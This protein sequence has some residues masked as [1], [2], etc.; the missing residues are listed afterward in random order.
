MILMRFINTII[1]IMI[2]TVVIVVVVVVMLTMMTIVVQILMHI[3]QLCHGGRLSLGD[4]VDAYV[5][6]RHDH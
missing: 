5:E 3:G 4:Y 6:Q 2:I 1:L